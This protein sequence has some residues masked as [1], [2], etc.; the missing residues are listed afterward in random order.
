MSNRGYI[1][2]LWFLPMF[3]FAFSGLD[4]DKLLSPTQ[5]ELQSFHRTP[6]VTFVATEADPV[7]AKVL[8]ITVQAR[9]PVWLLVPFGVLTTI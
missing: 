7:L 2:R 8:A 1:H 5:K 6:E 3:F 4:Q 9:M